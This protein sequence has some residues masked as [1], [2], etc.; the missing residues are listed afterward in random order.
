MPLKKAKR[1]VA[2]QRRPA[3]SERKNRVFSA[4]RQAI[5]LEREAFQTENALG[6]ECQYV[7]HPLLRHEAGGF[8]P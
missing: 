3:Q 4:K 1:E 6:V 2:A 7:V 5:G 8:L